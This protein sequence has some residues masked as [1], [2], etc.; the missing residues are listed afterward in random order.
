MISNKN[1]VLFLTGF[2]EVSVM[3]AVKSTT[4][5][6]FLSRIN[7]FSKTQVTQSPLSF[8]M[9][10]ETEGVRYTVFKSEIKHFSAIGNS[11]N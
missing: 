8:E 11:R 2:S 4:E 3:D 6:N 10:S 5:Q 1:S 7:S 9:I